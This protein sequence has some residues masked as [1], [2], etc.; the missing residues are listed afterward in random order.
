VSPRSTKAE[1]GDAG[2]VVVWFRDDLRIA[3]NP[4]LYAASRSGAPVLCVYVWDDESPGLR[5]PGGA[6][7]WW[8]HHSLT[9]L[10]ASLER[11]GA[12]LTVLCGPSERVIGDLLRETNASAIFWNRRYGGAERR[13]DEAIKTSAREAG[14]EATSFG[15]SLLFEPWTIRTGQ[16]TAFSVYTPFWRAC[17]S[18]PAPRKPGPAPLSRSFP[19]I[20]GAVAHVTLDDPAAAPA[21]ITRC[22]ADPFVVGVRHDVQD[23]R[24]GF[25]AD[26]AFRDGVR[27]LGEAGLPFDACVRQHQLAELADLAEACPGT[28]VVLDHLGKPSVPVPDPSWRPAL[29]RL[30][31]RDNV[32]CKLSGLATE[33]TDGLVLDAAKP[34]ADYVLA[35]FGPDRLMWG[36]DWPVLNLRTTYNAWQD[37]ILA[38]LAPQPK[39]A[40]DAIIGG[41]A[42]RFYQLT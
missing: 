11:L 15:A 14:V 2:P 31:R 37:W 25:T 39:S 23:E 7:R 9:E 24:P 10:A 3:D 5:A 41:T 30:A 13:I 34:Y 21:D 33:M 38:W 29:R 6:G 42:L 12:T 20:R 40:R 18:A 19:W 4:A 26:P 36:S 35:C 32:V 22:A 8:L 16:G 1:K 17:L 28:L 27:T